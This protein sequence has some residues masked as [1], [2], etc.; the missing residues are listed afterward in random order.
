MLSKKKIVL[1][2]LLLF[3]VLPSSLQLPV[4]NIVV[5]L[6]PKVFAQGHTDPLVEALYEVNQ[7]L[8]NLGAFIDFKDTPVSFTIYRSQIIKVFGSEAGVRNAVSKQVSSIVFHVSQNEMASRLGAILMIYKD[9]ILQDFPDLANIQTGEELWSAVVNKLGSISRAQSYVADI[10]TEQITKDIL[11]VAS[12]TRIYDG[13]LYWNTPSFTY[14]VL[15]EWKSANDVSV[16]QNVLYSIKESILDVAIT[17]SNSNARLVWI[18]DDYP[19]HQSELFRLL[20]LNG[21][22]AFTNDMWTQQTVYGYSEGTGLYEVIRGYLKTNNPDEIYESV[23]EFIPTVKSAVSLAETGKAR[24]RFKPDYIAYMGLAADIVSSLWQPADSNQ[25]MIQQAL[26]KFAQ[27]TRLTTDALMSA[28]GLGMLTL[29]LIGEGGSIV[30][31]ALTIA[32]V[33]AFYVYDYTRASKDFED[34]YKQ[35][36]SGANAPKIYRISQTLY[37]GEYVELV[38]VE[39]DN[40]AL[41]RYLFIFVNGHL[42]KIA[43]V[44]RFTYTFRAED[45]G[46]SFDALGVHITLGRG[47]NYL[48][49]AVYV[50]YNFVVTRRNYIGNC[51]KDDRY[52]FTYTWSVPVQ[53]VFFLNTPPVTYHSTYLGSGNI[54]CPPAPQSTNNPQPT[55]GGG[56]PSTI[57]TPRNNIFII[58]IF[59]VNVT[60]PCYVDIFGVRIKMP[61]CQNP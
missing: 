46:A 30:G 27:A 51:F 1:G 53:N 49:D 16:T 2:I 22:G 8:E 17:K 58:R 44:N 47:S 9:R 11:G 3:L 45:F 5:Y 37:N 19:P 59:G 28:R 6:V 54:V 36:L 40:I 55:G 23:Q 38:G 50:D 31:G 21:I 4:Y 12:H 20:R 60:L 26:I 25:A 42:V 32:P 39:T 29:A 35:V 10:A 48:T 24:L 33:M 13:I 18:L 15:V 61:Y 43:G 41:P 34:L 52:L 14:S 57:G 56:R 7:V